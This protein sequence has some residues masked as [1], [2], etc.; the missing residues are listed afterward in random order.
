M[1][2]SARRWWSPWWAK[3]LVVVAIL[4]ILFVGGSA[5]AA[6]FTE[7]NKS[8]GT[9]CQEMWPYRDTWEK[10]AHKNVD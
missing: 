6:Q 9:D 8:C 1:A 2:R 4:G 3:V 10:S 5:F 7:S